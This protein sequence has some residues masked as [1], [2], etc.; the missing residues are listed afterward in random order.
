M[1]NFH[2]RYIGWSAYLMIN[3]CLLHGCLSSLE[4]CYRP[5]WCGSQLLFR[6]QCM[7]SS[8]VACVCV[9]YSSWPSYV[10]DESRPCSCIPMQYLSY[11]ISST[12]A[13]LLSGSK[14]CNKGDYVQYSTFKCPVGKNPGPAWITSKLVE[15]AVNSRPNNSIEETADMCD[16]STQVV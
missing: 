14:W 16:I 15:Y 13:T 9:F 12:Y 1:K 2:H 5:S 3:S 7:G 4:D 11:W 8:L 10:R 6:I